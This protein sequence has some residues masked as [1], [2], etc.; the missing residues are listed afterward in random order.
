MLICNLIH[1]VLPPSARQTTI[2]LEG[3]KKRKFFKPTIKDSQQALVLF[4]SHANDFN[5]TLDRLASKVREQ[6]QSLQPLV[7]FCS[8]DNSFIVYY[9]EIKYKF[10]SLLPALDT[11]FKIFFVLNLKY[12]VSCRAVWLF[13]Q[14]YFFDIPTKE[15]VPPDV[16]ILINLLKAHTK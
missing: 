10:D 12:P 7:V 11:C 13:I 16:L 6:G 2:S 9:N 3:S 1:A 14:K 5:P 15:R 8:Y 4:V